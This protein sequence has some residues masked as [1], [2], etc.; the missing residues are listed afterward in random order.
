MKI[1]IWQRFSVSPPENSNQNLVPFSNLSVNKWKSMFGTFIRTYPSTNSN[2]NLLPFCNRSA[3]QLK[4][5]FGASFLASLPTSKH[6]NLTSFL[7][8]ALWQPLQI[9]IW[10]ISRTN[11]R[12]TAGSQRVRV[13]RQVARRESHKGQ[14][15]CDCLNSFAEFI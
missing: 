9:E 4:S 15:G 8:W 12:P 3:N 14:Q 2:R 11:K 7:N 5:K 6:R 13:R 1:E 10:Y